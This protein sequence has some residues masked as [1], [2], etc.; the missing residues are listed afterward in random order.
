MRAHYWVWQ[1][2]PEGVDYI[3]FQHYRRTFADPLSAMRN[4]PELHGTVEHFVRRELSLV[5]SWIRRWTVLADI[6]VPRPVPAEPHLGADYARSHSDVDWQIL[7]E[8]L[9]GV[10]QELARADVIDVIYRANMFLMRREL[11]E[12]TWVGGTR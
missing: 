7:L 5:T 3:G 9:P 6:V 10:Y 12:V 2:M 11:F 1:H 4:A 8:A